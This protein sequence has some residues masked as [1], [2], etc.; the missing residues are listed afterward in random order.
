M[1]SVW[2]GLGAALAAATTLSAHARADIDHHDLKMTLIDYLVRIPELGITFWG[3]EGSWV[4]GEKW[5]VAVA[6]PGPYGAA[7]GFHAGEVIGPDAVWLEASGC[8]VVMASWYPEPCNPSFNWT[9]GGG[10]Q[11]LGARREL[12]TGEYLYSWYRAVPVVIEVQW[13]SIKWRVCEPGECSQRVMLLSAAVETS[14]NTPIIAGDKGCAADCDGDDVPTIEDFICF[15]TY[16][17]LG[18]PTSDCDENEALTIDDF[19][20]FQTFFALGC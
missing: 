18:M 2:Y 9:L 8:G 6:V 20:C 1:R 12:P 17:A 13:P 11:Y 10:P 5:E 3:E 15:Q 14:P 16:F 19:I 4:C 7:Q